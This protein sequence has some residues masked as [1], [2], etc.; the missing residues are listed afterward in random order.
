MACP[1]FGRLFPA[2]DLVIRAIQRF[3]N[4]SSNHTEFGGRPAPLC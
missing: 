1:T 3:R 4:R 2:L